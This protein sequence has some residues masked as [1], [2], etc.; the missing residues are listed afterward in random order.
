MGRLWF[1]YP[2]LVVPWPCPAL[3][4]GMVIGCQWLGTDASSA[5]PV[6]ARWGG[7]GDRRGFITPDAPTD[8]L[9]NLPSGTSAS[10]AR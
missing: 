8:F 4:R 6:P 7:R 9:Q 10:K 2:C 5:D 3:G 1:G